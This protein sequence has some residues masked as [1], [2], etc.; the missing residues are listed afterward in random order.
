MLWNKHLMLYFGLCNV[1][2]HFH[3]DGCYLSNTLDLHQNWWS[4][5]I[6]LI[7]YTSQCQKKTTAYILRVTAIDLLSKCLPWLGDISKR[8]YFLLSMGVEC[9]VPIDTQTSVM[10]GTAWVSLMQPT[11][12][13]NN[14]RAQGPEGGGINGSQSATPALHMQK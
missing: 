2:R 8:K 12:R 11:P 10:P 7:P 3:L 4:C 9:Y 1:S 14:S 13:G 6:Y 5:I